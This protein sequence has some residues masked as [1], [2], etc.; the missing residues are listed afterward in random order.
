MLVNRIVWFILKLFKGAT[1]TNAYS[2]RSGAK[3]TV[4]TIFLRWASLVNPDSTILTPKEGLRWYELLV[5]LALWC[6][7]HIRDLHLWWS[8]ADL[9][10]SCKATRREASLRWAGRFPAE[11]AHW[12]GWSLSWWC[13]PSGTGTPPLCRWFL[14]HKCTITELQRSPQWFLV[15]PPA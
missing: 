13:P 9:R 11:R 8:C 4:S 2:I 12:D 3:I 10:A 15:S 6:C 14:P 1:S 5:N 7:H